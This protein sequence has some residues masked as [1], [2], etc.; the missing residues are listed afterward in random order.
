[1]TPSIRQ[2]LAA[3]T[4]TAGATAAGHVGLVESLGKGT[5]SRA[6]APSA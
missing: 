3:S 1:M 6:R 4:L 2:L 5:R